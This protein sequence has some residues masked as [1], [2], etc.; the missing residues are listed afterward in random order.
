MG[1]ESP[2]ETERSMG[3]R[4]NSKMTGLP[5]T[6]DKNVGRISSLL[7][8]VNLLS[9]ATCPEIDANAACHVIGKAA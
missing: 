9:P 8:E 1:G 5:S 2:L 7:E 3:I 4:V 6:N